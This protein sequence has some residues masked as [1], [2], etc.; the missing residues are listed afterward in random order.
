MPALGVNLRLMITDP[1]DLA[2]GKTRQ[3]GVGGNFDQPLGAHARCHFIAFRLGALVAPDDGGAQYFPGLVQHHQAVH[4]PG[5]TQGF[6]VRGVH[7]A[8]GQ[9]LLNGFYRRLPPVRRVLFRPA[10]LRLRHGVFHRSGSHDLPRL[11]EEDRFGTRGTQVNAQ[12]V[13]HLNI[14]P[15]RR[16][17][18][19]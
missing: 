9:H 5:D 4:L 2:G 3:R 17:R 1:Q 12:Y 7:A 18:G 14:P 16:L 10:V 6:H 8:L 11:I 15:V 13:F 19:R